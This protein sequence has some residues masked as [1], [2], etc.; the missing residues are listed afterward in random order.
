MYINRYVYMQINTLRARVIHKEN[1]QPHKNA[2]V[3]SDQTCKSI[4]K[5][6]A[7]KFLK[8]Q[9]KAGLVPCAFVTLQILLIF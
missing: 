1:Y 4:A 3:T 5:A 7:C 9:H 2:H 8:I 6:T